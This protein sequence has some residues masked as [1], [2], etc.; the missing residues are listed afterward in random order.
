MAY[1]ERV[2]PERFRP[3]PHTGGAW[4]ATEQH[5]SPMMGLVTHAVDRF[6]AQRGPD[7][8]VIA[9]ISS[10]ILG[11]IELEDFDVHVEVARPGRTIELLEA[12]VV[13]RDRP[14][15]RSRVWRMAAVDTSAV[16][17]GGPEKLPAPDTLTPLALSS[18]WSGGYIASL[19]V[20]PVGEPSAGR[21]TAWI[22][23]HAEL[24]A[25]EESSPAAR[26]VALV[27]TAN[28]IAVRRPPAEWLFPNLDLTVHFYRQ[29]TGDWVGL[30]TTVMFGP[31]G[32]G[33]T[34]SALHD[35]AGPVGRSEQILTLRPAI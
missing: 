19:D 29:P 2:G 13:W 26:F 25:G 3:T 12:T 24:V 11:V 15:M 10:D 5:I 6:V 1:F 28:G 8:M 32:Q 35:I 7:P 27:D 20:R 9:R 33:L 23:T 16:A 17:G 21:T 14:M 18:I 31:T 4:K 30:D 34:S 22:S